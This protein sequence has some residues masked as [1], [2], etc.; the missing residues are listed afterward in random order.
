MSFLFDFSVFAAL[1]D[2]FRVPSYEAMHGNDNNIAAAHAT[3][4][5][6]LFLG[7]HLHNTVAT[8]VLQKAA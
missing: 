8:M 2:G 6:R 7:V 5:G 4:F 1:H 3:D